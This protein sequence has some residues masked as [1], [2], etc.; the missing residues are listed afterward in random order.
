MINFYHKHW[1]LFL[2][3]FGD[4]G[5][6]YV[7]IFTLKWVYN[8]NNFIISE[9]LIISEGRLSW[10][11]DLCKRLKMLKP[12]YSRVFCR[13]QFSMLPGNDSFVSYHVLSWNGY[14]WIRLRKKVGSNTVAFWRASSHVHSAPTGWAATGWTAK[15]KLPSEAA[16]VPRWSLNWRIY[17]CRICLSKALMP[18]LSLIGEIWVNRML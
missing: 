10:Q 17:F 4:G 5:G 11:K 12:K 6:G 9:N 14:M 1:I 8:Q 3:V 18:K 2:C 7:Q 13:F 15:V 16:K